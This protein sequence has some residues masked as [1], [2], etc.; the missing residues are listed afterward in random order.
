MQNFTTNKQYFVKLFDESYKNI[1]DP[2][3]KIHF[4]LKKAVCIIGVQYSDKNKER[5]ENLHILLEYMNK[6]YGNIIDI[7]LVEQSESRS[8]LQELENVYINVTYQHLYN[9]TS[10]NR[11]WGYN[12]AVKEFC[13][14]YDVV[15]FMDTD[16]LPGENFLYEIQLCLEG[17]YDVISPYRN[18]YYSNQIEQKFIKQELSVSF[19]Q[20]INTKNPVT[21]T[22]GIV[23]FNKSKFLEICGFEQYIGYGGEDR[24]LDV[25]V[26]EY[27][28]KERIRMASNVYVHLFHDI[29]IKQK[30]LSNKIFQHLKKY[31]NCS[32]C[33]EVKKDQ[34]IHAYCSHVT[35]KELSQYIIRRQ[36]SFGDKNLYKNYVLTING[37]KVKEK[38]STG[39]AKVIIPPNFKNLE[40][41]ISKEKIKASSCREELSKL[42]N[43][44]L[45]KRCF[46]I[47]NG[48]SLNLHDLSLLQDEYTFAVNSFY[49]KTRETGFRPTFYVVEDTSV[50]KENLS[51][52]KSYHS[53]YKFFPTIYKDLIP[54]DENTY[55]FT[56][57]RGFYEKSS[58]NY[59]V[60]RFSTDITKEIFCGQSVTYINLQLAYFMGFCEVYLIGMDFSYVIPE[61][62]KRV[63]DVL[64][65]DSDDINHFH[66]DYF[67]AGKTWKDP[68]LD[69]VAQNYKM[70]K[71][72][73]ESTNRKIYN[74]TIGGSLEIFPRVDYN[75]LFLS[76]QKQ[77]FE[78]TDDELFSVLDND[79]DSLH[80]KHIEDLIKKG[81]L[82]IANKYLKYLD[83]KNIFKENMQ[84]ERIQQLI[85]ILL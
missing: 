19:I 37:E 83:G 57:N 43:K 41:Y 38:L 10:Y 81:D 67:G 34:F 21:I 68:K 55:F 47:G 42:Y 85:Q 82:E 77:D 48:P 20:N 7:I 80:Y 64:F 60:P 58:P 3:T 84:L 52:I 71:L 40:N 56:M 29:D 35:K 50:M 22:G 9:P 25:V 78:F 79:I 70:A 51:E 39:I 18:I 66:K 54:K 32:Y 4:D 8:I 59:C 17:I 61:T 63:G 62:H 2:Q 75:N 69:R 28:S 26:L 30:K 23:I 5:M 53:Q 72:V 13:Q 36:A 24:A 27:F 14:D 76:S 15:V 73:F 6:Y 44:Y 16:I 11:G 46:I 33:K 31:Y 1:K 74:A 12:T 45:G 49:Y 65:S